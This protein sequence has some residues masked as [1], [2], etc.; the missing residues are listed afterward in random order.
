MDGGWGEEEGITREREIYVHYLDCG[1][2][3]EC[4]CQNVLNSTL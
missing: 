2:G 4:I 1:D 3:H